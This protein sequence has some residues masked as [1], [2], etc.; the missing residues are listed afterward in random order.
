[1]R[2]QEE[3]LREY[4]D[5]RKALQYIIAAREYDKKLKW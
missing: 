1:M 2:L 5:F 3:I 4:R